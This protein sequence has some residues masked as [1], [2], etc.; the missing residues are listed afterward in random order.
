MKHVRLHGWLRK[1]FGRDFL[2][3]I[4][5]PA[6]AVRA[7]CSQLPNF[8]LALARDTMGMYVRTQDFD[9]GR[10]TFG[11]PFGSKEVLHIIPAITGAKAGVG[12]ILLGAV[13]LAAAFFT[14]G[15]A[16]AG[17]SI[18]GTSV[19]VGQALTTMG[20]SMLLGGISQM[21]FA[22]PKSQKP[23]EKPANQ[24]SYSFN[25]PVNTVQQGNAVPIAYGEMIVGTQVVSAGIYAENIAV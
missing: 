3:D 7:L 15:T 25:G 16:L 23:A 17:M 5:N 13:M 11:Y 21:L 2:L 14:A 4:N 10:E 1:K 8:K 20:L 12:Q 6:E 24:P 19:T 9:Y 18:L 22:P